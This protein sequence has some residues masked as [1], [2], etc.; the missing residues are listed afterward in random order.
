MQDLGVLVLL[1][2]GTIE[3]VTPHLGP[4]ETGDFQRIDSAA[5]SLQS[6]I[7]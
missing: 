5:S 7:F 2:C 1:T 6:L 4:I 3:R